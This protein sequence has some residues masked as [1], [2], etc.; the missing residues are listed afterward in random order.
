MSY[1]DSELNKVIHFPTKP[2]YKE[3]WVEVDCG[4]SAGLQWGGDYPRDC[5]HCKGQGYYYVHKASLVMAEYPGGP[6]LGRLPANEVI[7]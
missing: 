5:E 4:C 1:Y 2:A 7:L 6:L 3:G